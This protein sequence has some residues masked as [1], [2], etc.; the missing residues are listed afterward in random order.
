VS[1]KIPQGDNG[2]ADRAPPRT[3]KTAELVARE[4]VCDIVDQHLEPGEMLPG[5]QAMRARYGVGRPALR[6]AIRVLEVH[7]LLRVKPGPGGGPM[8]GTVRPRAF[9]EM[10]SLFFTL[11]G[12]SF[13]ELVEARLELEPLA[14]RLA[15]EEH[16]ATAL[17]HLR[18]LVECDGKIDVADDEYAR[19]AHDFHATITDACGNRVLSLMCSGLLELY[20]DRVEIPI[21]P[22]DERVAALRSRR[23]IVDAIE[24][25]DPVQAETLMKASL[26]FVLCRLEQ[27]GPEVL[28]AVID[29]A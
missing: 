27:L 9:G 15:A 5:E 2:L 6:E 13:R 7:G 22:R 1:L 16:D 28:D 23:A 20:E 18:M 25:A 8:I 19:I 24:A 17:R 14:A 26:A 12:T 11:A 3:R 29:W 4:I 21:I 10:A